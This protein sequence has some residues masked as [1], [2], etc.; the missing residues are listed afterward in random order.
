MWI[1]LLVWLGVYSKPD[2]KILQLIKEYKAIRKLLEKGL[3]DYDR[4]NRGF[5]SCIS[6]LHKDNS[7]IRNLSDAKHLIDTFHEY[8]PKEYNRYYRNP[9]PD[10][11]WFPRSILGTEKRIFLLDKTI[12]N[13]QK[14]C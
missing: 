11:Y 6:I 5:C 13:L 14:L 4:P 10:N 7:E 8:Y 2:A 1:K 9:Y 12:E 3:Q